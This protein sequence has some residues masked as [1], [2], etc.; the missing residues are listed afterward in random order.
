MG[1]VR[2]AYPQGTFILRGTINNKG[3]QYIHLRYY[4]INKYVSRTTGISV[5]PEEWDDRLQKVRSTNRGHARLNAQLQ[6]IREAV[7]KQ[8]MEYE[9][10]LTPSIVTKMLNGEYQSTKQKIAKIDFF[11]YAHEYNKTRYEQGKISFSYFDNSRLNI[12]AFR[13]FILKTT[14]EGS[15]LLKDVNVDIFNDYINYRIK[16]LGNTSYDGINNTLKP[17]YMAIKNAA[18]NEYISL[19]IATTISENYLQTKN[20]KYKTEIEDKDVHYLTPEQLQ[21]F[22]NLYHTVKYD[23]TREIMDMFLFAFHAC[24]LRVSDI[25][26]LEWSHIDWEN[27]EISKNLFKGSKPHTVP[28]TDSALEILERWKEKNCNP[29][30]VFNL[31][32]KTFDVEDES[33]MKMARLSKNRTLLQ[34]L[35]EI[36]R[37]MNLPF[38][39]SMHIAR[40]TF[41]VMALNRGV[42][43]HLISHLMGHSSVMTT[44]KVYAEFLP[45]AV[46]EEVRQKLSF[47][48][49]PNNSSQLQ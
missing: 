48:L 19:R 18:N 8:I 35:H 41:A 24:G 32:H 28:L 10:R 39:L 36:G 23:R 25:I 6:H 17:L 31:L 27:K 44:E 49:T 45:T 22:V 12:E 14:G 21:E 40:H 5:K 2:A 13:K 7:D 37:K 20:R 43:L 15:L 3:E 16:E 46:N 1:R 42:T 30:F 34:S 47:N 29:R 38:S 4:V 9:G 33:A 26:T 11:D